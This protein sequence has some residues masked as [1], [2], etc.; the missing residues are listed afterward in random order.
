MLAW[1]GKLGDFH[2]LQ[3]CGPRFI[4]SIFELP[5][6]KSNISWYSTKGDQ[7]VDLNSIV[8]FSDVTLCIKDLNLDDINN[9][10]KIWN[11]F[12]EISQHDSNL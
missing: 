7:E 8:L 3:S 2:I 1:I 4:W 9:I 6:F 12:I 11:E 5:V 10:N